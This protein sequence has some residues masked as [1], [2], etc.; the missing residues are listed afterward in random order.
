MGRGSGAGFFLLGLLGNDGG[1]VSS[2]NGGLVVGCACVMGYRL[3]C[4]AKLV[5]MWV[6]V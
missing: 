2:Y 6:V 4:G 3:I 1:S 5:V